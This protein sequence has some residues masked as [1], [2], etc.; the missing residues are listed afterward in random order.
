GVYPTQPADWYRNLAEGQVFHAQGGLVETAH[1]LSLLA[2]ADRR[3]HVLEVIDPALARGAVVICDRY[4]DATLGGFVHRGVD[5]RF[6][7][8]I[9][10]GI[11]RP[12]FAFYL[13]LTTD[14]LMERLRERDG[15]NLKDEEKSAEGIAAN[16]SGAEGR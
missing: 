12:D 11:P 13:R 5:S 9:N 3:R 10:G 14:A 7:A 15:Q 6:L 16:T 4:V 2:A 1:I 8:S